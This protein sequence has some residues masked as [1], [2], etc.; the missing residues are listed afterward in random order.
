MKELQGE[1][2]KEISSID[3]EIDKIMNKTIEFH[4]N[5]EMCPRFKLKWILLY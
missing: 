3:Y 2:A 5:R 4:S 1:T